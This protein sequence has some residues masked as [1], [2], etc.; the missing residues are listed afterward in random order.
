MKKFSLLFTILST[1]FLF[2]ATATAQQ[3]PQPDLSTG[4]VAGVWTSYNNESGHTVID[5]SPFNY[6]KVTTDVGGTSWGAYKVE[7]GIITLDFWTM[8]HTMSGKVEEFL[9]P[10]TYIGPSQHIVVPEGVSLT[11][12]NY[13][14]GNEQIQRMQ[15]NSMEMIDD[16]SGSDDYDYYLEDGNGNT[17]GKD[18]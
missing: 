4:N 17:Y 2:S 1:L 7:N 18:W 5:F 6:F 14:G 16:L 10:A 13:L 8:N 3:V 12:G 11:N 9:A 15:M